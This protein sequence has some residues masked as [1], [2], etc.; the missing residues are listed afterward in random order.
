L[1]NTELSKLVNIVLKCYT[2]ENLHSIKSLIESEDAIRE[3]IERI[4]QIAIHSEEA[5]EEEAMD[6][7]FKAWAYGKGWPSGHGL[8]KVSPGSA[9]PHPSMPC[10]WAT[11]ET[12]LPPLG[13]R[14]A[15]V[16]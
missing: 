14:S 4:R 13:G 1:I 7:I 2:A 5:M 11:P 6:L 10:R 8:P 3:A 9:M 12:A 16:F 15:A